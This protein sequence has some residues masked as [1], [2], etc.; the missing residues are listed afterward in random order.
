[1][2]GWSWT[3]G[4]AQCRFAVFT[5]RNSGSIF[6]EGVVLAF[7]VQHGGDDYPPREAWYRREE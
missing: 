2:E 6:L 3:L 5:I 7:E 1:M 4:T